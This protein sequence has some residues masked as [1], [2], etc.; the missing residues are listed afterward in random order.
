MRTD[1]R[2]DLKV[3][4]YRNPLKLYLM[5]GFVVPMPWVG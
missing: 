4:R 5:R 2:D 3:N 1:G